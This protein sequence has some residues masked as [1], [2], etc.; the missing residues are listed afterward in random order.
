MEDP[1]GAGA[2]LGVVGAED[3]AEDGS[4][5][6]VAR[7]DETAVGGFAGPWDGGSELD[8]RDGMSLE[9][10]LAGAGSAVA[11]GMTRQMRPRESPS[12]RLSWER[13]RGG[14]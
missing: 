8:A 13:M 6:G 9:W 4:V 14:M 2:S 11:A 7:F 10:I 5:G 3:G 12:R 1:E